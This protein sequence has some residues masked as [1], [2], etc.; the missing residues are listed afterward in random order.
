MNALHVKDARIHPGHRAFHII[1]YV[2]DNLIWYV[3]FRMVCIHLWMS[4]IHFVWYTTYTQKYVDTLSNEW[5]FLFQ[6]HP[7]LRGIETSITPPGN[8]NRQ[9]MAVEWPV[10]KSLVTF[11]VT[12]SHFPLSQCHWQFCIILHGQKKCHLKCSLEFSCTK[13]KTSR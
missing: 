4:I 13:A 9:R 8:L 3:T 5:M 1:L 7:L 10:L 2:N 6:P 11:N 12:L